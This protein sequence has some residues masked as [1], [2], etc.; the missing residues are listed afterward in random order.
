MAR[1]LTVCTSCGR[2]QRSSP[3]IAKTKKCVV[4]RNRTMRFPPNAE[5]CCR[6]NAKQWKVSRAFLVDRLCYLCR[7]SGK[8]SLACARRRNE[9]DNRYPYCPE[10]EKRIEKYA[11]R[12]ALGLP[13]FGDAIYD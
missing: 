13:L 10:R 7:H 2:R 1:N 12:A 8:D 3:Q 4:C 6:C 5:R 11:Q 9:R